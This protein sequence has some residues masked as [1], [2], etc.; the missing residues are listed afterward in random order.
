M[1]HLD[2]EE[3]IRY[4]TISKVDRESLDLM[5]KVNGHTRNCPACKEIVNACEKI[6]DR[7]KRESLQKGRD[8]QSLTELIKENYKIKNM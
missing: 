5:S 8:L 4:V 6:N 3:I 7:F 2:T 1:K